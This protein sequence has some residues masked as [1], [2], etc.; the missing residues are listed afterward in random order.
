MPRKELRKIW[1]TNM[2]KAQE[3]KL[4]Q[5][6]KTMA[7]KG[8]LKRKHGDSLQRAMDRFVYGTMYNQKKK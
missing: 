7:K 6:A 5:I 1:V 2:P 4:K 8:T 3:E